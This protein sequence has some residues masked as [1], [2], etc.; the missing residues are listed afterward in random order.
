[1]TD[2]A[3]PQQEGVA[4]VFSRAAGTYDRVGPRVF[5]H[6]GEWLVKR[7]CLN[8]GDDVLDVAAGRGAVLFPA[9]K[10]VG[11]DG[12]VQGIDFS[13]DMVRETQAEIRSSNWPHVSMQQM[14]ATQL[15]FPSA[16]FDCVL[17]GFAVFFFPK[18]HRALCEFTRVL[19]PGGRVGLTTWADDSPF[20][21]WF[22]REL[23]AS[24]PPQT[25]SAGIGTAPAGFDTPASLEAAL[26]QAGFVDIEIT[27]ATADFVYAQDEEWWLSLWSHGIRRRLEQL[28][29]PVLAQVKVDMLRRVRA[30]KQAD[31]IHNQFR[32]HC[33][34]GT[35]PPA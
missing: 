24:L 2:R 4:G 14:D 6:F 22:R 29:A 1:M 30:L 32:A 12:T 8:P 15:D 16:T 18:P 20:L 33:A 25:A 7:A 26:Q 35:K 3:H 34:V 23:T 17:C 11:S 27:T 10:A 19:R 21:S 31:G 5:T 13:T 28:E 9:A